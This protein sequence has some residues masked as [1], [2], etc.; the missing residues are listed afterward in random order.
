MTHCDRRAFIACG[1]SRP[2]NGRQVM[3]GKYLFLFHLSPLFRVFAFF[4][5]YT[6]IF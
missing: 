3:Q 4:P 2:S 1:Q 5:A 6:M